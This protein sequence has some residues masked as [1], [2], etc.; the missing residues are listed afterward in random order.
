[1]FSSSVHF[2]LK[3]AKSVSKFKSKI[4]PC[5]IKR[6]ILVTT[7]QGLVLDSL[8]TVIPNIPLNYFTDIPS[9]AYVK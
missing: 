2:L 3:F 8:T 4:A 1:M 9:Y 5:F 7:L 6:K